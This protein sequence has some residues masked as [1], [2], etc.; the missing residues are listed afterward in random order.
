MIYGNQRIHIKPLTAS[1]NRAHDLMLLREVLL[2]MHQYYSIIIS[3]I[4]RIGVANRLPDTLRQ[5]K[6]LGNLDGKHN[7]GTCSHLN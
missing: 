1:R 7:S 5:P 2:T 4:I 6:G 3:I